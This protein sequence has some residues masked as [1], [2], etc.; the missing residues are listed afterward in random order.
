[1]SGIPPLDPTEPRCRDPRLEAG[2]G[3]LLALLTKHLRE[4]AKL[5]VAVPMKTDDAISAPAGSSCQR[6]I[7]LVLGQ[8]VVCGVVLRHVRD[9]TGAN[10]ANQ[11][12]DGAALDTLL[13]GWRV[14]LSIASSLGLT[15]MTNT[16]ELLPGM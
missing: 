3:G 1:M 16:L 5:G 7:E 2:D 6:S 11:G 14:R 4:R 9:T 12:D 8:N 15:E 13:L 10:S